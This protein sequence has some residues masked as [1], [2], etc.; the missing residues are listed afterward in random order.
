M[1]YC[2]IFCYLSFLLFFLFFTLPFLPITVF[3][4]C[5][6]VS[7]HLFVSVCLSP[8]SMYSIF[9]FLLFQVHVCLYPSFTYSPCLYVSRSLPYPCICF[10]PSVFY[11]YTGFFIVSSSLRLS[12]SLFHSFPVFQC[13]TQFPL[14]S[15]LFVFLLF[16]MYSL[17]Y[18]FPK[19]AFLCFLVSVF[20][21]VPP[22]LLS[23]V[24]PSPR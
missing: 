18:C 1:L 5:M 7:L 24:Y 4:L 10:S 23:L 13:F 20:H 16:I 19:S 3:S 22:S 8:F 12:M 14:P 21:A 11:V 2:F 9:F 6:Y 15:Y 17:V